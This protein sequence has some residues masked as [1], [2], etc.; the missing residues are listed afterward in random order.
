M[1]FSIIIHR[2]LCEA[3]KDIDQ[4]RKHCDMVVW[5]SK[6]SFFG[7]LNGQNQNGFLDLSF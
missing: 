7:E 6:M 2:L 3:H 4:G 1:V 5:A